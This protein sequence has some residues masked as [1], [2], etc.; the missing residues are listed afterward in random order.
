MIL[1]VNDVMLGEVVT[2]DSSSAME[3]KKARGNL[4]ARSRFIC[5]VVVVTTTPMCRKRPPSCRAM[6][7]KDFVSAA[8]ARLA[9]KK[10]MRREPHRASLSRNVQ[11]SLAR[12]AFILVD[13]TMLF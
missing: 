13:S 2:G 1:A 5:S 4:L 3:V 9:E 7:R 8:V 12:N 6:P 10:V 11:P